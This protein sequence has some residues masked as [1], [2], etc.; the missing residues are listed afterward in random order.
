MFVIHFVDN[1]IDSELAALKFFQSLTIRVMDCHVQFNLYHF[2]KFLSF[3]IKT[4]FPLPE[5][6]SLPLLI[7]F[8][9]LA[10]DVS[11]ILSLLTVH[12]DGRNL[13]SLGHD[14]KDGEFLG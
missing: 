10:L 8:D 6:S 4:S 11:D 2:Y 13:C 9:F 1:V 12:F 14:I 7:I 5:A 3:L